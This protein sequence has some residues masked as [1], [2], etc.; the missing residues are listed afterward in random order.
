MEALVACDSDSLRLV[1]SIR[2]PNAETQFDHVL[3][4][5]QEVNVRKLL[6]SSLPPMDEIVLLLTFGFED[7]QAKPMSD[8][9]VVLGYTKENIRQIKLRA[10]RKLGDQKCLEKLA[11]A[12]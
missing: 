2:D 5:T 1:D 7:G 9:G 6:S 10:A 12:S 3:E 4:Q 8:I 11:T